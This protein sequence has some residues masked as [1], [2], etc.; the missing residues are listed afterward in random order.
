[1]AGIAV[2][3]H[4]GGRRSLNHE[5][6]L[7]PFIDFLLC[8]VAFLLVT[9][10]WSQMARLSANAQVPGPSDGTT[11]GIVRRLHLDVSSADKFQLTWREGSTVLAKSDVP[12]RAEARGTDGDIGYPELT[13]ALAREWSA[14]G[15]HRSLT[16]RQQDTL[17][18]HTSNTLP[19][20][21]LSAV[22]DAAQGPERDVI[23]LDGKQGRAPSFSVS[24]ATD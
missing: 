8:L 21:E 6:P 9:A 14:Q 7:V 4:S 20:G 16:D 22:L 2:G 17:V 18:V 11:E 24:F 5:L 23:G 12:R 13:E 3:N 1:M 10:V 15:Q 19:F